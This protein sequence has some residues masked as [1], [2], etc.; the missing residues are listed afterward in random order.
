[1]KFSFDVNAL[2]H[3]YFKLCERQRERIH[4]WSSL[5]ISRY[6]LT[7]RDAANVVTITVHQSYQSLT[8]RHWSESV[9]PSW[10]NYPSRMTSCPSCF[11]VALPRNT[12]F[13]CKEGSFFLDA[14]QILKIVLGHYVDFCVIHIDLPFDSVFDIS[15]CECKY[16]EVELAKGHKAKRIPIRDVSVKSDSWLSCTYSI[17]NKQ[18][19]G[20]WPHIKDIWVTD[21]D[22]TAEFRRPVLV[23]GFPNLKRI[24]CTIGHP[25]IHPSV[26][27]YHINDIF[28]HYVTCKYT[29]EVALLRLIR[30]IDKCRGKRRPIV[31]DIIMECRIVYCYI[32]KIV[33][34]ISDASQRIR[35]KFR[36]E[37]YQYNETMTKMAAI[38]YEASFDK[39][40]AVLINHFGL[41]IASV[42]W[43]LSGIKKSTKLV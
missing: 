43:G 39:V 34:A 21:M 20:A 31:I 10:Y 12:R 25:V 24:S 41:N 8:V 13:I 42:I 1:M 5:K 9:L 18:A 14:H 6:A 2:A 28:C 7:I 35:I 26:C 32:D 27:T 30:A 23:K 40:A 4:T 22:E 11:D 16:A 29:P 17:V 38:A 3:E 19:D 15:N 36:G 33:H 37:Y